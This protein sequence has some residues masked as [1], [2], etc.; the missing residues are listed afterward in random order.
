MRKRIAQPSVFHDIN[1]I[2]NNN[3]GAACYAMYIAEK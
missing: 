2:S 3:N 1:E